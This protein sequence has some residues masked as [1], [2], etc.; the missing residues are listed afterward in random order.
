MQSNSGS[1]GCQRNRIGGSVLICALADQE[2]AD[3]ARREQI[4]PWSERPSKLRLRKAAA[5]RRTPRCPLGQRSRAEKLA[6][7]PP[8]RV[9]Y[10]MLVRGKLGHYRIGPQGA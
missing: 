9:W 2:V 10:A 5:S 4:A 1:H 8:K 7:S 6:V 3:A